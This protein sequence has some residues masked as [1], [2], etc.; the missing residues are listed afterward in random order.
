[1]R[2]LSVIPK[3][4]LSLSVAAAL[5][6]LLLAPTAIATAHAQ[7]TPE[8]PGPTGSFRVDGAVIHPFKSCNVPVGVSGILQSL[9]ART[10]ER[11]TKGEEMAR[12]ADESYVL[13]AKAAEEKVR[14]H[15]LS[16]EYAAKRLDAMQELLANDW[17][18]RQKLIEAREAMAVARARAETAELEAR[19]ARMDLESCSV[20]APFNGLVAVRYKEPHE[21]V[22]RFEKLCLIVDIDKVYAVAMV[23]AN[24][25]PSIGSSAPAVFTMDGGRYPG[26]VARIGALINPE[27]Q[28]VRVWV[29]VE[30]GNRAL[31]PGMQGTVEF[32]P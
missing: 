20:K 27:S 3:Y 19:A 32:S 7:A 22:E 16:E 21:A 18:T 15:R 8:K 11:V 4:I 2:Q 13:A 14:V 10:G 9:S 31:R 17:T 30:N 5:A 23:P 12:V 1:M 26:T 29:L 6:L 28:T 25:L 24:R